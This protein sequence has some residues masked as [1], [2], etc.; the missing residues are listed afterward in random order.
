[1][2]EKEKLLEYID[3]PVLTDARNS[4]GCSENWYNPYYAMKETFTKEEIKN[5]TDK[6]I[7]N[8]IKLAENIMEALYWWNSRFLKEGEDLLREWVDEY[9]ELK[10]LIIENPDLPLIFFATYEANRGEYSS[11]FA[12]AR[13]HKGIVLNCMGIQED[14]IYTDE[15]DLESDISDML[16]DEHGHD[17][18]DEEYEAA[19]AEKMKEYEPYWVNA[20]IITVDDY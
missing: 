16:F 9:K 5:M 18:S 6:E 13:A 19:V 3:K 14:H 15:D 17:W 20:I 4:M 1:M 11:E 12:D 7:D 10:Q 8:L 2:T